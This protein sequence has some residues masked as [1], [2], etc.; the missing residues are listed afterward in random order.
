MLQP[1]T[2]KEVLLKYRLGKIIILDKGVYTL[3]PYLKKQ[4]HG[5]RMVF[6]CAKLLHESD[7]GDSMLAPVMFVL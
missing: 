1:P 3:V 2:Y 4:K 6:I 5:I 7:V